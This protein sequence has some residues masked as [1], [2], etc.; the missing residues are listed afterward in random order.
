MQRPQK[1]I[2]IKQLIIEGGTIYVGLLGVGSKVPLPRIE[3]HDLGA[4]DQQQS[5]PEVIDQVVRELLRAIGPAIAGSGDLLQQGGQAVLEQAQQQGIEQ[6]SEAAGDV[7]KQASETA[8]DALKQASEGI[9][10]L[11]GK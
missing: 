10:S 4:G 1:Q 7:V 5:I 9:K 3:M 11:F 6:V 8:E 2:L